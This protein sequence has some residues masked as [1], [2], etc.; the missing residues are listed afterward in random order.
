MSA[1]VYRFA[2]SHYEV[3]LQQGKSMRESI[4]KGLNA[5][6]A[7][8]LMKSS[9]PKLV[10]M[11]LYYSMAKRRAN[12]MLR[13][14]IFK[15]HPKQAQRMQGIADGAGVDLPTILFTQMLEVLIGCTTVAFSRD[16]T[17]TSE[18]I[19]AKNFDY[20]TFLAPYNFACETKL[21]D[22]YRTLGFK[23]VSLPGMYDGMNEHG[24]AVTYNLA[25]STDKPEFFVPTGIMLQEM[26]ETCVNVDEGVR[27]IAQSKRGGH[28]GLI[29]LA[30]PSGDIKTVEL[31]SH[32]AVVRETTHGQVINTNN[33]QTAEMQGHEV[34][35]DS[36]DLPGFQSSLGRVDRAMELLKDK[37]LVDEGAICS[38]LRDHGREGFPSVYT[39]CR[40]GEPGCTHRSMI[41]Y[42]D[43]KTIKVL[44]GN[45]CQQGEYQEIDFI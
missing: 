8:E 18:T 41:F 35:L 44:F 2:G 38:V 10:P 7:S 15:Y 24:L 1:K 31:S 12:N 9:K 33:Y 19:M 29:T 16:R 34:P 39:I 43:R 40:H 28:D 37:S 6:L 27:M 11:P 26:L 17:S 23:M 20:V 22:G 32:Y 4:H 5:I 13:E 3:G 30:D 25:R 14:D 21:T 36:G 42:P 45:P